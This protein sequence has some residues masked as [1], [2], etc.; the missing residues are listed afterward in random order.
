MQAPMAECLRS[1]RWP[2]PLF[3]SRAAR[4]LNQSL[5]VNLR[6]RH[7]RP[8]V[9]VM[10]APDFQDWVKPGSLATMNSLDQRRQQATKEGGSE[11]DGLSFTGF[12]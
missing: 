12:S 1:R 11:G 8:G 4:S 10:D 6:R 7:Y 2:S 5:A 3:N 9:N